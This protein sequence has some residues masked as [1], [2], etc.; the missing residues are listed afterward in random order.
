MSGIQQKRKSLKSFKNR[1][2]VIPVLIPKKGQGELSSTGQ[3][4]PR[5]TICLLYTSRR[6]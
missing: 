4:A 5:Y 3:P 1:R 2:K 6:G